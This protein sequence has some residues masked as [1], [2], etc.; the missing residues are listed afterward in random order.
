MIP[1]TIDK[2][3]QARNYILEGLKREPAGILANMPNEY[4]PR[5]DEHVRHALI[6]LGKGRRDHALGW[7]DSA[8]YT[9]GQSQ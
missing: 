4:C 3:Y 7:I 6:E 5:V 1:Q 2:L 8:I 9:S